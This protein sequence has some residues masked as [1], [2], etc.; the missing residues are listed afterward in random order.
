[1]TTSHPSCS[2][3]CAAAAETDLLALHA[4]VPR[5]GGCGPPLSHHIS[6][7]HSRSHHLGSDFQP[8]LRNYFLASEFLWNYSPYLHSHL[9][10]TAAGYPCTSPPWFPG[11]YWV[12]VLRAG[13]P[14]F[15][16]Q[17]QVSSGPWLRLR[18]DILS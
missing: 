14:S 18:I 7:T 4:S 2:S 3:V 9:F 11:Q 5:A 13:D 6:G 8:A 10:L 15:L 12:W 1:M 17:L 16:L